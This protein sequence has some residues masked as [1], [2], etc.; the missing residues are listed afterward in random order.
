MKSVTRTR[1][2]QNLE[3][4][5]LVG[6][7]FEDELQF[8]RTAREISGEAIGNDGLA[9]FLDKFQWLD[10]VLIFLFRLGLPFFDRRQT[11]D[12]LALIPHDHVF[13]ETLVEQIAVAAVLGRDVK[14]DRLWKIVDHPT[15][16]T[17]GL[18][19]SVLHFSVSLNTRGTG[20]RGSLT[21]M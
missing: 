8:D 13:G 5:D 9:V 21:V 18:A 1:S 12:R 19:S 6:R 10:R 14:G 20:S 16:S 17:F 7:E 3:R 15:G 2:G 11:F 4:N